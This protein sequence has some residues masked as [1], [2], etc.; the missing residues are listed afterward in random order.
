[1]VTQKI[2]EPRSTLQQPLI[3]YRRKFCE[4][5]TAV[6]RWHTSPWSNTFQEWE[7][8]SLDRTSTKRFECHWSANW[9]R[10]TPDSSY[11]FRKPVTEKLSVQP[12]SARY[13]LNKSE[14]DAV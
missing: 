9:P 7:T 2:T 3:V 8:S 6:R 5:K 14:L 11:S 1:M 13:V 4:V 12:C 10:M